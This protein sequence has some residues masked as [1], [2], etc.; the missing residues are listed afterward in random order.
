MLLR[1]GG[2]QRLGCEVGE[3]VELLGRSGEF[4]Q[5]L[6]SGELL[7]KTGRVDKAHLETG[8]R[9]YQVETKRGARR[10]VLE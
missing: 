4:V 3:G 7:V 8:R 9:S 5:S 2:P 10:K 6:E 1:S